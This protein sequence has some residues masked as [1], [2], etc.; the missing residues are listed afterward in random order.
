MRCADG[1][2]CHRDGRVFGSS[3]DFG[4]AEIG[5]L[6]PAF[7]IEQNI[8]WL[9]VAVDDAGVMG[10][11]QCLAY[12]RNNLQRFAGCKFAFLLQLPQVQAVTYSMMK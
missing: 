5:D 9:D 8:V 3:Q 2:L 4:D 6:H 10:E 12:L 7:F 1:S 11:L